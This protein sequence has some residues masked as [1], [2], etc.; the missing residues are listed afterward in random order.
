MWDNNTQRAC[1][2]KPKVAGSNPAGRARFP[3]WPRCRILTCDC[4]AGCAGHPGPRPPGSLRSREKPIHGLFIESCRARQIPSVA[5]VQD[6]H[7]RL[8]RR[9]LG[10][11]LALALRLPSVVRRAH[12]WAL[13]RI[14]SGAP[15]SY[16][17]A[18]FWLRAGSGSLLSKVDLYSSGQPL[19]GGDACQFRT[20]RRPGA[21]LSRRRVL[22]AG[23]VLS[24]W[25]AG[26]A[27]A[28]A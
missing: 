14:P 12:P 27:R 4:V 28:A 6:S 7:L 3:Q 9:L 20:I 8:R 18:R 25:F 2:P 5:E 21:P 16:R 11:S 23:D 13:R 19:H 15:N 22:V 1:P 10:P 17:R 24:V 26:S